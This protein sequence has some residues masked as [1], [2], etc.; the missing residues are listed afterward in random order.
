[1]RVLSLG[2]RTVVRALAFSAGG[3]LA[4]AAVGGVHVWDLAGAAEPARLRLPRVASLA[5]L[6][7]GRLLTRARYETDFSVTD[8]AG[9]ASAVLP[10]RI[11]GY[12]ARSAL[13]P[14]GDWLAVS[15]GGQLAVREVGGDW[16]ERWSHQTGES[17]SYWAEPAASADRVAVIR[18]DWSRRPRR[19]T[20][21]TWD[22]ATGR[23]LDEA[24]AP[25]RAPVGLFFSPDGGRLVVRA[26]ASFAVL[27]ATAPGVP[28]WKVS[29]AGR[30][31]IRGMA[32]HPSGR[33]LATVGDGPEVRFW[34]AGSWAEA[35]VFAWTVGPLS[36][37]AFS[38][39]GAL[40]AAGSRSGHVVVWDVDV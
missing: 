3:K 11:P 5:F 27:D 10:F 13:A 33:L 32:F 15:G 21:M 2:R 31:A 28:P 25:F 6:P 7:D 29:N 40:A 9:G 38:P 23:P 37:V 12:Y 22:A 36:A 30:R 34:D 35:R 20:L 24:D 16:P 4:A 18:N 19:V 1:M 26:V 17:Q 14:G 39:D 8:P